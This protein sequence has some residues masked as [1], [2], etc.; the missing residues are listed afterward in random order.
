MK[1]FTTK[2]LGYELLGDFM[3]KCKK[4]KANVLAVSYVGKVRTN[5]DFQELFIVSY[6]SKSAIL[7]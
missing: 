4:G 7:V 5:E 2:I 1:N 6:K 3:E